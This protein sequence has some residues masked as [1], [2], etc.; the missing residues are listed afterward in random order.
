MITF[1]HTLLRKNIFDVTPSIP[2]NT[3]NVHSYVF[4]NIAIDGAQKLR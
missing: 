2:V 4:E 3:Y 1:G